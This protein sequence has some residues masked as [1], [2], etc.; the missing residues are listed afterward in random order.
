MAE[1]VRDAIQRHIDANDKL[2]VVEVPGAA[3]ARTG[4]NDE[5]SNWI[6]ANYR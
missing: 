5:G 1:Q 4:I 2:L 6:R 3:F